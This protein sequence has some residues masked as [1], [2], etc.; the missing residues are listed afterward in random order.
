MSEDTPRE[1][2]RALQVAAA[3]WSRTGLDENLAEL[4]GGALLF[5]KACGW[6]EPGSADQLAAIMRQVVIL[7]ERN[8]AGRPTPAGTTKTDREV[9]LS[10]SRSALAHYDKTRT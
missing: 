5:A 7:L 9:A 10:L 8:D 4:E 3:E 6:D 1:A 2:S